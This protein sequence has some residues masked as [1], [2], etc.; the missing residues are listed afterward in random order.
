VDAT[1]LFLEGSFSTGISE[2]CEDFHP[3][4]LPACAFSS[5]MLLDQVQ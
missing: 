4:V 3:L 2:R 1:S 5:L